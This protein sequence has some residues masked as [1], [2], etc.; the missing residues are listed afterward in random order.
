VTVYETDPDLGFFN[1]EATRLS[2]RQE[3]TLGPHMPNQ[4]DLYSPA[5][6]IAIGSDRV[7]LKSTLENESKSYSR[8]STEKVELPFPWKRYEI[9]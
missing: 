6:I 3:S 9:Y 7:T 8:H 1:A 2:L 5:N 4:G